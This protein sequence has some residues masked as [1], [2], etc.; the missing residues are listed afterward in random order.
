MTLLTPLEDEE[1]EKLSSEDED[2][3]AGESYGRGDGGAEGVG[4]VGEA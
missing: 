1:T 3:T 2:E 4:G